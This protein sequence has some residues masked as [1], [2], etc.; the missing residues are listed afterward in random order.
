MTRSYPLQIVFARY[1][2]PLPADFTYNVEPPK[3]FEQLSERQ[4]KKW[5]SQRMAFFLLHQIFKEYQL[6]ITQLQ[7]IQR[8]PSGRPYLADPRIDFNISHSAIS[9]GLA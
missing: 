7:Q 6:D 8:T 2:E 3:P 9:C 1:D 5:Q 4:Q